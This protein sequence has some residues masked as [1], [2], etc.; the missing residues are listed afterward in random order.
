VNQQHEN[1]LPELRDAFERVVDSGQFILGPHVER[2]E[3]QLSERC[4]ARHTIACSS[5]TDAML[6]AMMAMRIGPGDEVITSPLTFFSTAGCIARLGAT[7]VF[8]DIN[9]RTYNMEVQDIEG[10]ITDKTKAIMP[11]HLYG[12][13]ANMGPLMEIARAHNLWVIEDAAQ[14]LGAAYEDTPVGA[15]GDVG[16]LS[17]YPTKSLP[18]MGDAGACVTNDD[19]LAQTM[20]MLRV[21]GADEG[22]HF[23]LIGGNFRIDALHAALLEVKLARL[24]QW[25]ARRRELANRYGRKLERV[26]ASTPFEPDVRHHVYNNYTIRVRSGQREA[27]RHHLDACGI[28]NRV[29]YPI[30]LHRQPCFGYLGYGKGS[31]PAVETACEEVLSLPIYP[32][33]TDA[34]QD[35]VVAAVREFFKAE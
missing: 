31:L 23:P 29:Y 2:F 1:L 33:L 28:G 27:L 30:P 13:P 18:A 20:R 5:G 11:V 6:M 19:E 14:A 12:L 7:P 4:Q 10:A 24:D 35:E 15:I 3:R 21:H 9:P 26:P 16:C 17:F 34:Q 32:E 25:I 22:Y 8:V